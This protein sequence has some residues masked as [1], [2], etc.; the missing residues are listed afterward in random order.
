MNIKTKT[1]SIDA[2]VRFFAVLAS[3]SALSIGVYFYALIATVHHT[4]AKET[5]TSE[6][7][8]LSVRVSELEYKG[9]AMKNTMNLDSALSQ[10]FSEV[11]DPLYVSRAS[12]SLTLNTEGR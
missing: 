8:A 5:L 4:V 9:L 3:L 6:K 2:R 1:I 7:L 12:V 11:K 10:G